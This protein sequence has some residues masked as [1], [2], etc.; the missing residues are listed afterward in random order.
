VLREA[1][2]PAG[3]LQLVAYRE[4]GVTWI[5][6]T[7]RDA[8]LLGG[9]GLRTGTIET[10]IVGGVDVYVEGVGC[11]SG[12]VSRRIVRTEVIRRD[13]T[14]ELVEIVD[15]PSSIEEEYR[16][17]WAVLLDPARGD[18]LVGYD[19]RGRTYDVMD[20]KNDDPPPPDD[21]RFRAMCRFASETLRYYSTAMGV[22]PDL[23][24][25]VEDS[26]QVAAYFLALSDAD[27]L[28]PRTVM[29]RRSKLVEE[30]A[31]DAKVNPWKPPGDDA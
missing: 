9:V 31:E 20:P 13:G 26:L 18:R 3:V 24:K 11:V 6:V 2:T 29:A 4:D 7:R 8:G 22:D 21:E 15:I 16:A 17:I 19:A 14:H 23:R 5:G 28:D 1:D 25:H 30:Y 12:A 27:A 10:E